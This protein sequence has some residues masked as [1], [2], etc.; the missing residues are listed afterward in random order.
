[1]GGG[2]LIGD[3]T[4]SLEVV[5]YSDFECPACKVLSEE[6]RTRRKTGN[7]RFKTT[8]KHYPLASHRFAEK[9]AIA[10]ECAARENRFEAMHDVLFANQR[11]IGIALWSE[12]ASQA[13]VADISQFE[14][15]QSDSTTLTRIRSHIA[16]AERLGIRATPTVL[17]T[18]GTRFTGVPPREVLDSIL[19]AAAGLARH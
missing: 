11:Q 19:R 17:L 4:S 7:P 5:I 8:Y 2:N 15:C 3:S 13:G 18:G 14:A 10:S 1:M 16:E 6:L 9:A 12:L